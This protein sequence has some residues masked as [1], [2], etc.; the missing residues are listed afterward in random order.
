MTRTPG[1]P[2]PPAGPGP[3]PAPAQVRSAQ[4]K[5]APAGPAQ[6]EPPPRRRWLILFVGLAA[7]TAGCTFQYG[8]AYL[9]PALRNEGFTLETAGILV[10]CPTVGL[11]LA[12]I[13]WG[14]AADR[15][16]ERLVLSVGLGLAGLI[17]LEIG[18]A[19]C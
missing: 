7:L 3:D 2:P 14:A 17:L 15:W 1:S 10:A 19:S 8:L 5:P 6:P 4:P 12:L 18:R 11:L 16:G 9:I 13:A